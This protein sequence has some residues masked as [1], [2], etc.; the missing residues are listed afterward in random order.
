MRE[1]ETVHAIR[2]VPSPLIFIPGSY[3]LWFGTSEAQE[4]LHLRTSVVKI[5]WGP[6][7]QTVLDMTAAPDKTVNPSNFNFHL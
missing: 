5:I 7:S 1:R 2:P 6:D 3:K 4:V